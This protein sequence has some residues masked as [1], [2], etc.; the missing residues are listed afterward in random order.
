MGLYR[1]PNGCGGRFGN[2]T[3]GYLHP[4]GGN[5]KWKTGKHSIVT[6]ALIKG[7]LDPTTTI[8]YF[9]TRILCS[10]LI[11]SCLPKGIVCFISL[12]LSFSLF[13]TATAQVPVSS[14]DTILLDVNQ[15]FFDGSDVEVPVFIQSSST[16]YAVDM[17]IRF[18]T[19]RIVFDSLTNVLNGLQ[20]LYYLN[21]IDSVWRITSYHP[22][23]IQSNSIVFN[24]RFATTSN[25]VCAY[26]FSDAEAFVNGDS[27]ACHIMGCL[28]NLSIQTLDA[29]DIAKVFPNPFHNQ[30]FFASDDFFMVQVY[31]SRGELFMAASNP[32]SIDTGLW[33]TGLYYVR[34]ISRGTQYTYKMLKLFP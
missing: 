26:D 13:Q 30:L 2:S 23:G 17:A 9:C 8:S 22:N 4:Y 19:V 28:D 10:G 15:S 18:N 25:E 32:K 20:Y 14:A 16:V 21:P 5:K 6:P 7:N 34:I 24:L 11:I 27:S 3:S 33:K 12:L 1:F 31:D 29:I